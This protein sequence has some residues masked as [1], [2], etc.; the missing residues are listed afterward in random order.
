[1]RFVTLFAWLDRDEIYASS[2]FFSA[3]GK[4]VYGCP[5]LFA[6]KTFLIFPVLFVESFVA[7]SASVVPAPS[8]S[9]SSTIL[10]KCRS[11]GLRCPLH[12]C[13]AVPVEE[14]TSLLAV[15]GVSFVPSGEVIMQ[16]HLQISMLGAALP[17]ESVL[18]VALSGVLTC[19]CMFC[20]RQC[21]EGLSV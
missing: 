8:A 7:P 20:L 18:K 3:S 15:L 16:V 2:A 4:L 9:V 1:M 11:F 5:L 6:I 14:V 19:E 10:Q 21:G 17:Q 13:L 12:N